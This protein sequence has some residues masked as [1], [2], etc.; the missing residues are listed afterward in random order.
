MFS[1]I[2]SFDFF[3]QLNDMSICTLAECIHND[4]QY[5]LNEAL[6][7]HQILQIMHSISS[8]AYTA[9]DFD[10]KDDNEMEEL[11]VSMKRLILEYIQRNCECIL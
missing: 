8:D 11:N 2:H 10:G 1:F 9:E 3:L 7:P 4:P 5:D 6:E